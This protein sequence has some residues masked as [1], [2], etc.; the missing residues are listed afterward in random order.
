LELASELEAVWQNPN[1]DVRLK[2]RIVRTLIQE[3]VAD[4]DP[5]PG[6]I[7]KTLEVLEFG[8]W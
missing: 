2:K 8:N 7:P 6:E 1:S 4:V 5:V 3:I